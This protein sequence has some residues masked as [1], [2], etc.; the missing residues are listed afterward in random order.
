MR[1][2][3]WQPPCRLP[4]DPQGSAGLLANETN[5]PASR[6]RCCS[7]FKQVEVSVSNTDV[8]ANTYKIPTPGGRDD[9]HTN[10]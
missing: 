6:A 9:P 2:F 3:A 7:Q 10:M 8:S 5:L 1:Q 4:A